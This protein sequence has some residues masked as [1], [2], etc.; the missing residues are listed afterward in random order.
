[1]AQIDGATDYQEGI[2]EE[3]SFSDLQRALSN[4][5]DESFGAYL[6]NRPHYP[7]GKFSDRF[8]CQ[9]AVTSTV[10]ESRLHRGG[11][12]MFGD[13]LVCRET[14]SGMFDYPTLGITRNFH[15]KRSLAAGAPLSD[16]LFRI[17]T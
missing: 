16:S 7:V 5:A 3:R 2:S 6:S 13:F 4:L 17:F 9:P 10:S 1:M 12:Q 11:C 8:C 14:R 15:P